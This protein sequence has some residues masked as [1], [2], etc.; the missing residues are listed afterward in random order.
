MVS[1]L[2]NQLG[3]GARQK[4]LAPVVWR[5]S[6]ENLHPNTAQRHLTNASQQAEPTNARIRRS[7]IRE[8]DGYTTEANIGSRASY[9]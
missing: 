7:F 8:T 3:N 5:Q 4:N 2:F 9:E 6:T 1:G